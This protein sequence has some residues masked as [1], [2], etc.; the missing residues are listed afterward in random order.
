MTD[1]HYAR[2]ALTY[3]AEP[4]G[5]NLTALVR[6]HGPIGALEAIR[7]GCLPG[8]S[9][10]VDR[11]RD[12]PAPADLARFAEAGIRVIV[13]GDA[14]WPRQ[15]ADLGDDEPIALWLSGTGHLATCAHRSVAIVGSHAATS[16]GSCVAADMATTLAQN[17]WTIVSGGAYGIDAAAHRGALTADGVT[18]AVLACGVDR[19]YPA[20]HAHLLD[21]IAT[22]GLVVSEWPPGAMRPDYGSWP[23]TASSRPSP[24]R[25]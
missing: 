20:G 9:T 14:E 23:E 15:L 6:V 24:V 21:T 5:M 22:S 7:T 10:M 8:T 18:V 1:E 16:Y 2:A 25:P 13:P 3:L 17:G 19:P 4:A 11:L 12:L